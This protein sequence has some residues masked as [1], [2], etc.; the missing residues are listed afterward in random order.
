MNANATNPNTNL[1]FKLGTDWRSKFPLGWDEES[2]EPLL[3][4]ANIKARLL[5]H[6][7]TVPTSAR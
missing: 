6:W 5:G 4:L 1:L 2:Y 3:A 7:R